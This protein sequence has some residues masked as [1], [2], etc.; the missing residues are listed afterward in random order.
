MCASVAKLV[1]ALGLEP[2]VLLRICGFKSRQT[3]LA[4]LDF[5][6]ECREVFVTQWNISDSLCCVNP[7]GNISFCSCSN[8]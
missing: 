3:Q 7:P 2:S 1:N 6:A 5:N 8:W 4:Y